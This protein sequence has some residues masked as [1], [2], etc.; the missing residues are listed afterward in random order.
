MTGDVFLKYCQKFL[1][2]KKTLAIIDLYA[3]HR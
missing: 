2:K 1:N 3:A